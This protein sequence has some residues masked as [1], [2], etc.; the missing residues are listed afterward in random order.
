MIRLNKIHFGKTV[1]ALALPLIVAACGKGANTNPVDNVREAGKD[2]ALQ[3]KIFK[4][5]CSLKPLEAIVSGIATNG[6][7]AIKSAREQ[8]QFVG[9][10]VH[11]VTNLYTTPDCT[12]AESIIFKEAGSFSIDET[13][14]SADQGKF[15]TL[16]MENLTVQI[17]NQDGATVAKSAKL[18]GSDAW[19]VQTERDVTQDAARISC[20]RQQVPSVDETLYHVEGNTLVFGAKAQ[21]ST[22]RPTALDLDTKYI[23]N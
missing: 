7:T 4:G 14:K 2:A 8:Y 6:S 3:E 12:G 19:A 21:R 20:Y 17:N 10:N 18:C 5:E 1:A 23:A 16:K 13:K 11:H 15:L 9:A 22:Q